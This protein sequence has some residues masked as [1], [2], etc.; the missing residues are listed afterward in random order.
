MLNFKMDEWAE[1]LCSLPNAFDGFLLI[2][3]NYSYVW[4]ASIILL[5]VISRELSVYKSFDT[6]STFSIPNMHVQTFSWLIEV[7]LNASSMQNV[8]NLLNLNDTDGFSEISKLLK[9]FVSIIVWNFRC[10]WCS[11]NNFCS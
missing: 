7:S 2:K 6:P 1:S 10:A 3:T 4:K 11:R 8:S 5:C 9:D